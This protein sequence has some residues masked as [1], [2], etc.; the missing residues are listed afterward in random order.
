[1]RLYLKSFLDELLAVSAEVRLYHRLASDYP[2]LA[3]Q[4]LS[5]ISKM[6]ASELKKHV[7][8]KWRGFYHWPELVLKESLAAAIDLGAL[9]DGAM[10]FHRR[11]TLRDDVPKYL[12]VLTEFSQK[13]NP[14]T[15]DEN[16]IASP[17]NAHLPWLYRPESGASFPIRTIWV[18][19]KHVDIALDEEQLPPDLKSELIRTIDGQPHVAIFVHPLSE[20]RYKD[21]ILHFESTFEYVATPDSSNRTLLIRSMKSDTIFYLMI[22]GFSHLSSLSG[23]FEIPGASGSAKSCSEIFK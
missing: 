16:V 23:S 14:K 12:A 18:P 10:S 20:E 1:M 17:N 7:F 9:I 5:L 15:L 8:D 11:F 6:P 2:F 3:N 13:R 22:P 19:V 4:E 21:L